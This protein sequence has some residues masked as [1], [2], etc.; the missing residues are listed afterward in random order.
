MTADW[1]GY[2]TLTNQG[3]P[4]WL[5]HCLCVMCVYVSICSVF[6]YLLWRLTDRH[7]G[8]FFILFRIVARGS[9]SVQCFIYIFLL[10]AIV[11]HFII[12]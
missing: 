7:Q 5:D 2:M 8:L 9:S 6:A 12:I 11:Y 1:S 4:L 10:R 3:P